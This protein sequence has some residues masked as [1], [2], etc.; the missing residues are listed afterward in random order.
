MRV[1]T[2]IS[3]LDKLLEGGFPTNS[4]ILL[5]GPPGCGKST[6]SQQFVFEGLKQKQPAL[7]ITL[8]VSP[9]DVLEN[10]EKF[11][12]KVS[13]L[14]DRKLKFID[15][16]SWRLGKPKGEFALTNLGDLNE[17]NLAIT[18]A[19]SILNTS[20]IR[21]N[22]FDSISTLLLYADPT[23]VVKLIPVIIA[24]GKQANYTQLLI[25]EEG[26]H[27]EKTVS[28]LNY[29]SDGVIEFKMEEDKRFLRISRMKATKHIRK[30]IEFDIT[31]KGIKIP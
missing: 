14:R 17:L 21:R 24:K 15:A 10:M 2:G 29:V 20:N 1:K 30:W 6:M 31:A 12:W 25:L 16:Y 22:V 27:D 23:L 19:I 8:D 9:Q 3:K 5:V 26:V 11:G 28:T 7:Y 4:A 18:E 13:K